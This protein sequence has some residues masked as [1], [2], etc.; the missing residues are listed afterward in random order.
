MILRLSIGLLMALFLS[1]G[2]ATVRGQEFVLED[3][4]FNSWL[5]SSARLQM[6]SQQ[7]G[8]AGVLKEEAKIQISRL[9]MVCDLSDDQRLRLE[10]ATL[11]DS[12]SFIVKVDKLKRELV[13]QSFPNN[14]ISVP[15]HRIQELGGELQGGLYGQGSL[16]HKVYHKVLTQEQLAVAE[17][18][19]K[20]RRQQ[21]HEASIGMLVAGL[22]QHT[23][24]TV[25]QR[26]AL[27]DLILEHTKPVTRSSQYAQYVLFYQLSQVPEEKLKAILDEPQMKSL[28]PVVRNGKAYRSMLEQQ[29]ILES[30]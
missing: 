12:T 24:M 18:A 10:L 6:T 1:R 23:P 30:Q 5:L 25:A 7:Q 21:H 4:T 13:G 3:S 22:E 15:Y 8:I 29:G 26:T 9:D 11:D 27:R 28:L 2:A 19:E 16:F 20:E 17:A 14:D